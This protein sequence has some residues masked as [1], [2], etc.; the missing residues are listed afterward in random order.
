VPQP[1]N[2]S[3]LDI[4]LIH[5]VAARSIHQSIGTNV[6]H[7]GSDDDA[8]MDDGST[9][10]GMGRGVSGQY[11][12]SAY[13]PNGFSGRFSR[14]NLGSSRYGGGAAAGGG[15]ATSSNRHHPA[16]GLSGSFMG[17]AGGGA[18][19]KSF[20]RSGGRPAL[21]DGEGP[22]PDEEGVPAVAT[23]ASLKL[24]NK[25]KGARKR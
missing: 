10:Q 19:T 1:P 11:N 4:N 23:M 18:S 13:R 22:G 24:E 7:N 5:K 8:H 25:K 3:G 2:G 17:A 9:G 20:F 12:H 14:T 21:K 16:A 6:G 15:R